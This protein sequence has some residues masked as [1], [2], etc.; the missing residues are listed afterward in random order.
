MV[1][2]VVVAVAKGCSRWCTQR[3]EGSGGVMSGAA[4]VR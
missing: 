2:V 3:K 1:V 4:Q